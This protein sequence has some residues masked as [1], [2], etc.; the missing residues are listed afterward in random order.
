MKKQLV[1]I[2]GHSL[3]SNYGLIRSLAKYDC[4]CIVVTRQSNKFPSESYSKYV[5]ACHLVNVKDEKK[6]LSFLE[7]NY[8][9]ELPQPIFFSTSDKSAKFLDDNY[10]R[11][12]KYFLLPQ[13]DHSIATAEK[14]MDKSFQKKLA[15]NA[16]FCVLKS[17]TVDV[18]KK[19]FLVP[20]DIQYPCFVKGAISINTP[21]K[22]AKKCENRDVLIA[23]LRKISKEYPSEILI[24]QFAPVEKECGIMAL[25]NGQEIYMPALTEFTS[26]TKGGKPGVSITGISTPFNENS[27][28]YKTANMFLRSLNMRGLCNIDLLF[29]NGKYYFSEINIRYAAYCY[30]IDEA[31]INLPAMCVKVLRGETITEHS[32]IE[33]EMSYFSDC[34]ACE[35]ILDGTLSIKKAKKLRNKADVSFLLD[36]KDINPYNYYIK[37]FKKQYIKRI[38]RRM[39]FSPFSFLTKK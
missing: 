16:G 37:Q 5:E 6:I 13:L 33:N 25:C 1:I 17:C 27:E 36:K 3:A 4:R 14:L 9:K 38:L 19:D 39:I 7:E 18:K 15:R 26:L 11:L 22:Y 31:G 20:L 29:I 8:S 24:E 35:E 21:K 34:K 10:D 28:L 12:R 23:H 2:L 30:S 32:T